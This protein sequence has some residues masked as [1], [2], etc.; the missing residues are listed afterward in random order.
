MAAQPT[1]LPALLMERIVLKF[2]NE[3]G[4]YVEMKLN[5]T[6]VFWYSMSLESQ[7]TAAIAVQLLSEEEKCDQI[8]WS[9]KY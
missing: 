7:M 4:V 5:L 2:E 8:N 3:N 9:Y 6:I 1:V